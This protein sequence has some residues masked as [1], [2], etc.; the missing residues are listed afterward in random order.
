MV[1]QARGVREAT[2]RASGSG[3]RPSRRRR[4]GR[5]GCGRVVADRTNKAHP[6][7]SRARADVVRVERLQRVG[8]LDRRWAK[9]R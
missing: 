1:E 4:Q 2:S 3:G 7:G 6:S 8:Q 9:V 5:G